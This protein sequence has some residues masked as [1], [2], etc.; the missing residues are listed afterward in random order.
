VRQLAVYDH[1]P[2]GVTRAAGERL[3]VLRWRSAERAAIHGIAPEA[4]SQGRLADVAAI[5]STRSASARDAQP[6]A[7]V[8]ASVRCPL[9]EAA[10]R[11]H[12]NCFRSGASEESA[13]SPHPRPTATAPQARLLPALLASATSPSTLRGPLGAVI[14]LSRR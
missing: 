14:A 6:D 8:T 3:H 9:R 4:D 11:G 12:E 7:P 10:A 1:E 2:H 5:L 13:S